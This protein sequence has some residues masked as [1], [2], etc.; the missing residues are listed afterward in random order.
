M[1]L[2]A[3]LTMAAERDFAGTVHFIF[4]P[5]EEGDG[6]ARVMVEDGL[7]DRFPCEAIFG[8]HN[9]PGL[10]AGDFALCVG[11]MMAA[12]DRWQVTFRGAG[13]HGSSPQ[14]AADPTMPAAAFVLALQGIVG[15]N[16]APHDAAVI[17]VGHVGAGAAGTPGVI[18]AEAVV[19][20]IARSFTPGVRDLMERRLAEVAQGI[21]A[22]WGCAA[23]VGYRRSN[24]ALV[25]A[26][27][28]AGLAVAAAAATVGADR[29][30]DMMA[31]LTGAEDFAFMLEHRP[32]A[33]IMIGNGLMAGG[34]AYLHSPVY[35]FNDAVIRTGVA[36]WVNLARRAVVRP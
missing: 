27:G 23:D 24:P 11:P 7:F 20:G 5:A 35:D 34:G 1:L 26:A 30:D 9:L 31:P 22:A 32:G 13:G 15:R 36:Y 25:N 18:P 2:G 6:G 8:L 21:A 14:H 17:S 19:Q 12:S 10:G 3:A 16:V 29:V 33:Y 28:P 4:Q